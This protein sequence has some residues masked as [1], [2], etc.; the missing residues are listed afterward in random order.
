MSDELWEAAREA[1]YE[2]LCE[3]LDHEPTEDEIDAAMDTFYMDYCSGLGDF[4]YDQMR[5]EEMGL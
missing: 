2:H 1:C 4:M 3:T 5:D